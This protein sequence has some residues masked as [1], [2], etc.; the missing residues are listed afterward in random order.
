MAGQG[1]ELRGKRQVAPRLAGQQVEGVR[2]LGRDQAVEIGAE[3]GAQH[4]AE[5]HLAEFA[6]QVDR[7]AAVGVAS[8]AFDQFPIE[9]LHDTGEAADH[10]AV[11]GRLHHAALPRPR[12]PVVDDQPVAEQHAHPFQTDP[13]DVVAAVGQQHVAD[14]VRVVDHQAVAGPASRHHAADV[15]VTPLQLLQQGQAFVAGV[16][17]IA[18]QRAG[19]QRV[20]NHNRHRLAVGKLCHAPT[21]QLPLPCP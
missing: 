4:D 15:A 19:G 5:G 14:V 21:S 9:P 1:P 8:P 13:L 3:Q 12:L 18:L 2:A 11:E 16:E 7:L 10:L 17:V 6:G 20:V